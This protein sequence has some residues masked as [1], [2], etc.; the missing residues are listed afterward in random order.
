MKKLLFG[1]SLATL[2]SIASAE[3]TLTNVDWTKVGDG[4]QVK[5]SG[6]DLAQ[7]KVIRLLN[8]KSFMLE[9]DARLAGKATTHKVN[10]GGVSTVNAYWFQ[11]RPAKV[12]VQIKMDPDSK[13]AVNQIDGTWTVDI[14]SDSSP[15]P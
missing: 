12:R 6:D 8:G 5:V 13:V 1:L 2:A 15:A 11:A 3:G 7:P 14:N 4:L 9:F 10:Y